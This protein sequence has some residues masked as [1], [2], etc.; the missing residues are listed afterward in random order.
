MMEYD[1]TV[2]VLIPLT[3]QELVTNHISNNTYFLRGYHLS[4]VWDK[5]DIRDTCDIRYPSATSVLAN[6]S[7]CDG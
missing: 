7:V 1:A 5:P 3:L 4:A 6:A 2:G